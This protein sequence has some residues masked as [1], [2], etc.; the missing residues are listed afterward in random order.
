[1]KAWL[2]IFSLILALFSQGCSTDSFQRTVYNILQG[3]QGE[4]CQRDAGRECPEP[5]SYDEYQR[6]RDAIPNK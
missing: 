6:E 4:Q 5:Q 3:W 2:S 1:M